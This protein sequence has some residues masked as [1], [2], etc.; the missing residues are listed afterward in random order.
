MNIGRRR[1]VFAAGCVPLVSTG[2]EPAFTS[3]DQFSVLNTGA[4]VANVRIAV[5]YAGRA[6]VGP[7]RLGVAPRRVRQVRVNDLI[8][9]VAVRLGEPYGLIFDSDVAVVVQCTRQDTGRPLGAGAMT[10]AWPLR[11]RA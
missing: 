6:E 4:S 3:R 2:T 1:W 11:C 8:F 5:L 9:P 10:N 7:F